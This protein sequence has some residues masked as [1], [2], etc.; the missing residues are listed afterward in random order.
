MILERCYRKFQNKKIMTSATRSWEVH[1]NHDNVR[2]NNILF[3][4]IFGFKALNG[5]KI[6]S[7]FFFICTPEVK[8][9][10]TPTMTVYRL[11]LIF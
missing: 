4:Y 11:T 1:C 6:S 3:L 9:V 7:S 10:S 8:L 2:I 5:F